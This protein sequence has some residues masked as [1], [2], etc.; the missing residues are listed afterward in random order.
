MKYNIAANTKG[1]Y[2]ACDDMHGLLSKEDGHRVWGYQENYHAIAADEKMVVGAR[3]DNAIFRYNSD[4][5]M[6][7]GI[8]S[9]HI[10]HLHVCPDTVYA[11]DM[12]NNI[13][14]LTRDRLEE[15][16]KNTGNDNEFPMQFSEND[17][18]VTIT[19]LNTHYKTN[20]EF[21]L[22]MKDGETINHT[23]TKFQEA[24]E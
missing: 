4:G 19:S 2:I 15:K 3:E 23:Y 16:W 21:R 22:N 17:G 8:N 6:G 18:V 10:E 13:F 9:E 5:N 24:Q 7:E 11:V 14:A 1:L 20:G 12:D